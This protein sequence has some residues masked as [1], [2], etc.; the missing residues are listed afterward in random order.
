[1][2]GVFGAT[3]T[4]T[5]RLE[6][7][8]IVPR[9]NQPG[10]PQVW[11]IVGVVADSRSNGVKNDTAREIHL[12]FDQSPFPR[13]RMTVRSEGDPTALKTTLQRSSAPRPGPADGQSPDDVQVVAQTLV[14]DQSTNACSRASAR[15]H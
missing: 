8:R 2:K 10:E 13:V 9:A 7:G 6:L 12:P 3:D 5:Q 4:L 15:S 14:G 11:Q 1:M